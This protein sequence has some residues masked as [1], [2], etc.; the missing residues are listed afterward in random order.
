MD[1]RIISPFSQDGSTTMTLSS[2]R[3][4]ERF[5][6]I[7]Q[8]AAPRM[9]GARWSAV[10]D[11]SG[12]LKGRREADD[13]YQDI[14]R[15]L[16][17]HYDPAFFLKSAA[18]GVNDL[19]DFELYDY[20]YDEIGSAYDESQWS[21]LVDYLNEYHREVHEY[22]VPRLDKKVQHEEYAFHQWIDES[23]G[24]CII[25]AA[26]IPAPTQYDRSGSFNRAWDRLATSELGRH[27]LA[28]KVVRDL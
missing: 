23:K 20:L 21:R 12:F 22:I 4:Q 16:H 25:K 8:L 17:S 10:L 11:L 14:T 27:H 6:T 26:P 24:L 7:P 1:R 9:I 15:V 13:R 28:Q 19:T 5:K 2:S 18:R 3:G